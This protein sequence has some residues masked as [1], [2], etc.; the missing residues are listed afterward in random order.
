M[1][2]AAGAQSAQAASSALPTTAT[3]ALAQDMGEWDANAD[4]AVDQKEFNTGF[5]ETGAFGEWDE[6]ASGGIAEQEYDTGVTS[7]FD[8]ARAATRTRKNRPL[9]MKASGATRSI[10]S[11]MPTRAAT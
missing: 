10:P 9:T 5:G 7:A 8:E 3:P 1:G 4:A 2:P 6:D 11:G